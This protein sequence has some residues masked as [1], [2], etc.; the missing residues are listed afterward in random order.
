MHSHK[1]FP[2]GSYGMALREGVTVASFLIDMELSLPSSER[3]KLLS[4]LT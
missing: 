2:C 1:K 3:V 4:I